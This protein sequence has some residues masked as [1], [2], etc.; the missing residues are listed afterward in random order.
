LVEPTASAAEKPRLTFEFESLIAGAKEFGPLFTACI[1]EVGPR[2]KLCPPAFNM[3]EA[4]RGELNRQV[5]VLGARTD[6][7]LQ[8]LVGFCFNIVAYPTKY[9]KTLTGQID[10][11]WLKPA[12]RSG[13][14]AI[15][16]LR[17][18][19]AYMR[20]AGVKRLMAAAPLRFKNKTGLRL[21]RL[22]RFMGFKPLELICEKYLED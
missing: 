3:P 18:N 10:L 1:K 19:E 15:N 16:M 2:H 6:D 21:D 8:E 22:Y 9:S 7:E 5:H 12:W 17:E 13:W 4:I 11:L 14:T 20:R